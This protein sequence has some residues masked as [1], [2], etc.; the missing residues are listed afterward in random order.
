MTDDIVETET[1]LG[2]HIVA[3][4]DQAEKTLIL[5]S[6]PNKMIIVIEGELGDD[7]KQRITIDAS[8]PTGDLEGIQELGD[9][10]ATLGALLG[11]PEMATQ[12]YESGFEE[13]V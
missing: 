12:F 8:G 1:V 13:E 5:N 6:D 10:L 3:G 4:D 7:G 9:V 2:V 11:S